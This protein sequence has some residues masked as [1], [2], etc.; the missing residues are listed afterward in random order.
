VGEFYLRRVWT[1]ETYKNYFIFIIQI[2]ND[3]DNK[4]TED[5]CLSTTK[6]FSK[7]R[8]MMADEEKAQT[9]LLIHH[10]FEASSVYV[11]YQDVVTTTTKGQQME[12]VKILTIFTTSHH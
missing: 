3:M 7:W 1:N 6:Y 2:T 8:E 5:V 12:L 4:I 9:E 10:K 11:Y